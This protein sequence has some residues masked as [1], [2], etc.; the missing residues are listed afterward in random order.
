VKAATIAVNV[1]EVV[2]VV[3]VGVGTAKGRA[4]ETEGTNGKVV[5]THVLLYQNRNARAATPAKWYANV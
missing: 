5:E 2:A 1:M 3:V 4:K